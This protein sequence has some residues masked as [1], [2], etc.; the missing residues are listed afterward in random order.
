LDSS[1]TA[2]KGKGE[3][4]S[5]WRIIMVGDDPGRILESNV[6]MNLSSPSAIANTDWIK[7]GKAS[8]DWWSGSLGADGKPAFT[9]TNMKYYVDFAAKSGLEYMLVDAGWSDRDITK[10]N[11]KVDIP[12]LVEYAAAKNVKVWI[13]LYAGFVA[14]QAEE[15]F[16]LY[17]K[18]GVAG[19]KIDFVERDD[20][21]GIE[22]YYKT[23]KSSR[24]TSFDDRFSWMYKTI[25]PGKNLSQC[26][27]LRSCTGYGAIERGHKR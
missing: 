13:W 15:A 14:K 10:M 27:E 8:W 1:G 4:R 9:T 12:D 16:A 3:I 5:A 25:W 24:R 19:V 7:A 26:N 17:E 22:F 18:W 23:A 6:V 21:E 2:V 20:Q 11:G